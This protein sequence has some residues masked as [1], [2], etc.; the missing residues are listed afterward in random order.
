MLLLFTSDKR[1]HVMRVLCVQIDISSI[2]IEPNKMYIEIF[3]GVF[4]ISTVICHFFA[5]TK[6]FNSSFWGVIFSPI[7]IPF[8]VFR[9]HP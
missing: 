8:V 2:K 4:I 5:K 3:I 6:G 9:S 1:R 7:T